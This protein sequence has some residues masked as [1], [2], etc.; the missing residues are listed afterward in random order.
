MYVPYEVNTLELDVDAVA[1]KV[2]AL[3]D[4]W[5]LRSD[6]FPFYTLGKSA[7][8]EG[9]IPSYKDGLNESNKLLLDNFYDMYAVVFEFLSSKYGKKVELTSKLAYPGFHIFEASDRFEGIAGNWHIDIPHKTLKLEGDITHT[10]T[11]AIQL[12][13]SGG[14][15]D[16]VDAAHHTHHLAYK[17]KD[18][19]CHD[20]QTVHRIA[21]FN[22]IVPGEYRIT[23]QGHLIQ[24]G[25][26]LQA[27]W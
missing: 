15:L 17:E 25:N 22:E 24:V 3:R 12:P 5:T 19:V 7:Y 4:H 10:F 16:W 2:L 18:I 11:V 9:V 1:D 8:I 27:Y 6:A 13:Q 14:G 21:G 26:K 20:G 23:L